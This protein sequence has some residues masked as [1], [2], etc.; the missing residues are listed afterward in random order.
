MVSSE[1]LI[2]AIQLSA[3]SAVQTFTVIIFLAVCHLFGRCP[4]TPFR[5]CAVS[6]FRARASD[7]ALATSDRRA[8]A[9]AEAKARDDLR[10]ESN[11]LPLTGVTFLASV[12]RM[13]MML[14]NLLRIP[15]LSVLPFDK[16]G[17]S[18][19]LQTHQHPQ[20]C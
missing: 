2:C 5:P 20:Q 10:K 15:L 17:I 8:K 9:E 7:F 6:L 11:F 3:P 18:L 16:N 1:T 4:A 19:C 13:E 12:V 14:I